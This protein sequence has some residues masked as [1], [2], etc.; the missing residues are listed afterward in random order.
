[1]W[2]LVQEHK[3]PLAAGIDIFAVREWYQNLQLQDSNFSDC[4]QADG[5]C[6]SD[7]LFELYVSEP[8]FDRELVLRNFLLIREVLFFHNALTWRPSS[9]RCGHHLAA[10][11][12]GE[13]HHQH[14]FS[15][16][17]RYRLV[18]RYDFYYF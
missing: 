3:G 6:A 5:A 10:T 2:H 14:H 16:L 7:P 11:R 18:P 4:S 8:A 9:G 1:M 12:L 15:W 13:L 17:L